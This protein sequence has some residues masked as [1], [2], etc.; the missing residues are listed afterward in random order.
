MLHLATT[1]IKV[2]DTHMQLGTHDTDAPVGDKHRGGHVLH[3]ATVHQHVS[4][5]RL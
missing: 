1:C 5:V 2:T 4:L 3:L